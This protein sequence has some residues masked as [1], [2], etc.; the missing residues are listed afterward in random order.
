MELL[1][2]A[3]GVHEKALRVRGERMELLARNIANG[4]TPHFKSRELDFKAVMTEVLP[5]ETMASTHATHFAFADESGDDDGL[6][7][8]VPFNVSMDGNTVEMSVE[9]AKYGKAAGD[10][11]ATLSFLENRVGSIRKALRGD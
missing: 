6:R 8:R 3:L 1:S 10:Y 11:Q 2:T 7:Y 4:D 9:Q 5:G